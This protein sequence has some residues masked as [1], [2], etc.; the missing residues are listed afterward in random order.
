MLF[1]SSQAGDVRCLVGHQHDGSFDVVCGCRY[2]AICRVF[3]FRITRKVALTVIFFIWICA[4]LI[5]SPWAIFFKQVGSL[6]QLTHCFHFTHVQATE[7]ILTTIVLL[8]FYFI[9]TRAT[10]PVARIVKTRRQTGRAPPALPCPPLLTHPLPSALLPS[11]PL[12][13][14]VGP[15]KSS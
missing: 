10:R 15:L 3:E 11:P 12:P 9:F 5:M 13:L 2:L 14:V 8:L 7:I 1:L 4:G 6:R